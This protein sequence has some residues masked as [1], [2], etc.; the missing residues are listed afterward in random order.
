MWRETCGA[1][2]KPMEYNMAHRDE[3]ARL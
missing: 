1:C 2:E 3:E